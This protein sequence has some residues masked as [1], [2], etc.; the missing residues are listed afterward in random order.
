V[1]FSVLPPLPAAA[2]LASLRAL[3]RRPAFARLR[4]V[5][6]AFLALEN[7]TDFPCPCSVD[8]KLC[9]SG[10]FG[11]KAKLSRVPLVRFSGGA[12][13]AECDPNFAHFACMPPKAAK[14]TNPGHVLSAFFTACPEPI[15]HALARRALALSSAVS[16]AVVA[17]LRFCQSSVLL[18][19]SANPSPSAQTTRDSYSV[20]FIDH[21]HTSWTPLPSSCAA[22]TDPEHLPNH[23]NIFLNYEGGDDTPEEALQDARTLL[24]HTLAVFRDLIIASARLPDVSGTADCSKP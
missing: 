6:R 22:P 7:V 4:A 19:F 14:Q 12:A 20:T 9:P 10:V 3:A 8:V 24:Q 2:F 15:R 5:P 11:V 13:N 1:S 21:A 23:Q 18:A 16:A 17:G